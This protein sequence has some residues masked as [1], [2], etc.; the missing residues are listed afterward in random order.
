MKRKAASSSD[1]DDDN[2]PI[3]SLVVQRKLDVLA[4]VS[5]QPVYPK[6]VACI[7][8][9]VARDFGGEHGVCSG[10][11]TSVDTNGRRPL[12]HVVCSDGDEE[13]YYDGELHSAIDPSRLV[14]AGLT[15][16]TLQ[17]ADHGMLVSWSLF[18]FFQFFEFICL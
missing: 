6:D 12:Y 10:T 13:D 9:E 5:S 11:I 8:I 18:L 17:N 4:E 16:D 15:F 7:G 1:V 14:K 2:I 3:V